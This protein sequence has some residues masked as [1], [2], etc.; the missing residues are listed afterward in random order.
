[1]PSF[2]S[3]EVVDIVDARPGLQR[4]TVALGGAPEPAYVLTE[5]TGTVAPGDRVVVNTTA[6][7][8]G[9][10]TGGWHVVHWNL[11]RGAL[12]VPGSGH[13]MKLRYTSLQADVGSADRSA[14]PALDGMPVVCAPLHSQVA[15]IVVAIRHARPDARVAYVMTDWAALPIAVSDLVHALRQRA[16][17]DTTITCAN[18]FGGDHEAVSLHG[19]LTLARTTADIA[20]VAPGPGG[21]GTGT[22]LG[23]G[24]IALGAALDAAATLGGAPVAALRVSFADPRDRHRGVSH[25]TRTT[26]TLATS[27]RARIALPRVGDPEEQVIRNALETSGIARRHDVVEVAPVG[28][29]A[30]MHAL[31]LDVDSMGRAVADDPVMFEAAAAAG[32]VA[33]G[34]LP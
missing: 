27:R 16:L 29:A 30:A 3:G 24:S 34:L 26:L 2:A 18:A 31:G 17:L 6:V 1:M 4:V 19:S 12:A 8:L 5:L 9:L 23:F 33:A 28:I 32:T 21:V 11:E 13:E 14:A 25:H 22:A 15:P 10:G 20:L 7:E